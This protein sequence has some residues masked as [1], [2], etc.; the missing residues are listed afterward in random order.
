MMETTKIMTV[1]NLATISVTLLAALTLAGC[2]TNTSNQTNSTSQTSS[3]KEI[4]ATNDFPIGQIEKVINSLGYTFVTFEADQ[5]GN[6]SIPVGTYTVNGNSDSLPENVDRVFWI[7]SPVTN[8]LV[9]L[10]HIADIS[11][12]NDGNTDPWRIII[13]DESGARTITSLSQLEQILGQV[14][15]N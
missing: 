3:S 7:A 6:I 13:D 5:G 4:I 1:R 14:N 2:R 15:S 8:S 11:R 9:A 12:V 10:D